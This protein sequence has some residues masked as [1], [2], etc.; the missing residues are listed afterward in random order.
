MLLEVLLRVLVTVYDIVTLPVYIIVQRPWIR[1]RKQSTVW[2]GPLSNKRDAPVVRY[3]PDVMRAQFKGQETIDAL[4]RR[5]VE[6]YGDKPCLGTRVC[7]KEKYEVLDGKR[8]IKYELGE[9]RWKSYKEAHTIVDALARGL[10]T[11]GHL[12]YSRVVIFADT[13]EEWM[14]IALACFRRAI[15]VCTIYATLGDE[16]LVHGI[17]ETEVKTIITSEELLSRLTRLIARLPTVTHVVYM[18]AKGTTKPPPAMGSAT[19]LPFQSLMNAKT[20]QE[21][22]PVTPAAQDT[23][24]IMYTSGS[25]GEPKGVILTNGNVVAFILGIASVMREFSVGDTFIGFLPLAH[26]ME[27]A[28]ET[29]FMSLGVKIGY[30]SP[31]TLTDQGTALLPGVIGDAPLLK[32]TC[33]IAVPLL[34][35][36]IRKAI[37]QA[38]SQK[39]C[40]AQGLFAFALPYKSYWR[41]KGFTT[42]ILNRIVFRNTKY[43]L[44]GQLRAIVCGSAPLSD[45]TQEFLTNCLDCPVLQGYGLTET[46]AGA[47]LQDQWDLTVGVAGPPL[48]GIQIKL[49]DWDE[50]GY[51]VSDRPYPR[52]EVV[53]GGPTV[54]AGYYKK[55]ELTAESFKEDGQMRWFYT[56]DIGQ[57]L[58]KGIL[59]IIDRKKDLVKLQYGEYVSLGKVETVLKTHPLVD[60]VC[61]YGSSLSTFIIA[62]IQPNEAALKQTSKS[63]SI[64]ED[65]SL[66]ELCENV[67]LHNAVTNELTAHCKKSGLVK[68][69]IPLKYKLCKEVWTP[70]SELVT[71]ALKIR[72]IQIQKFYQRDINDMYH[73]VS[74]T[75]SASELPTPRLVSGVTSPEEKNEKKP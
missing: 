7:K 28:V 66:A 74:N 17:N 10:N 70:E 32:P 30:S 58:P 49:V 8:M 38:L 41:K 1:V 57:F 25:T 4:F 33:M 39:G 67:I 15:T 19:V 71:A 44:G 35:N 12:P 64:A 36:R 50:G 2:A 61:V 21:M 56:G 48:N 65:Q 46:T 29:A 31:F 3:T 20:P 45:D 34:L 5:A 72:R 73:A 11:L 37:E 55:P 6:K 60:N 63:L 68:Y 47:T 43:I 23:V 54:A 24:I 16:G 75:G 52:G 42:P 51:Y 27:I 13:R 26:V 22:Q 9:Y 69:E 40:V 14:L 18:P 59:Q 53:V 62:L